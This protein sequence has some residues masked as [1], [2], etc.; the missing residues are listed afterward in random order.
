[1]HHRRWTAPLAAIAGLT[2][3]LLATPLQAQPVD[4]MFKGR[5][6]IIYCSTGPGGGYDAYARL[7]ARHIGR[8]LPGNPTVVVENMPGAGGR[9]LMNYLYNVAPKNGT[10]IA[11]VQHTT[12]YDALFGENGVKY[13]AQKLNWLGSMAS[14]TSV[15]IAWHTSGVRSIE[16]ARQK[17]IVMGSSGYGATS[18]Q[19]TNL[20][21]RLLG[22]KFKI[23][24]GYKGAADLYIAIE[25]H[26]LDGVAGT[27]WTSIRNGYH[28]WIEN[29]EIN[30]FVQFAM[31][32]HPDLP[33]VPLIG[34]LVSSPEDKTVLRF[35][36]LGL[37]FARPFLAPPVLPP[38][39]VA[40]L[41]RA[42][43]AATKDPALLADSEKIRFEVEP[44]DGETV[45]RLVSELYE[46]PRP[47]IERAQW[48][49]T[50]R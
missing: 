46:T 41:R 7:L 6:L 24:V 1:M 44:V 19:W 22:T 2:V 25:R 33:N 30:I 14:F 34:D 21:N 45:Q 47:L 42:F 8:H 28:R 31:K 40:A 27:D 36:F 26:E 49:L 4:E 16:D 17:E 38:E 3:V 35:V 18:F 23:L 13:D 20:M 5:K 50:T 9:S 11:T 15:G 29:K 32:P 43:D 48:A 12:V 10:A 39:T 37:G